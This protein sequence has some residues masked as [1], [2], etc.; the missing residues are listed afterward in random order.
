M[1]KRNG[2]SGTP[3]RP[4]RVTRAR[5]VARRLGLLAVVG[6]LVWGVWWS[7]LFA[8]EPSQV[9]ITMDGALVSSADVLSAVQAFDGTALPRL[10]LGAVEEAVTGVSGVRDATVTRSWPRGLDVAVVE[11]RPVAA[12]A[13]ASEGYV[14]VDSEGVGLSIVTEKPEDLP[15]VTVPIGE[16]NARILAA[17]LTVAGALP[18]EL[19]A[20]VEAVRAETEDSVTLFLRD[21]PRVDWGS[22]EDSDL[23]AEVLVLLLG[24]DLGEVS[25]ID[26]SAPTLPVTRT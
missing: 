18:N 22:G 25:V 1:A 21:G 4:R 6:G 15:V 11:R 19:S 23:K 7:P 9:H 16:E 3:R 13:D 17:A 10:D 5:L 14:I 26:V 8:L 2:L 24:S 12:I 20:R